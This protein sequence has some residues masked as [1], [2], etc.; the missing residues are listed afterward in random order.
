MHE[1]GAGDLVRAAAAGDGTAWEGLVRRYSG[2]VWSVA[3][4][5]GL[6]RADAAD[7]AQTTWLRLVEHLT[8][9]RDPEAV[10]AWLATTARYESLRVARKSGR[11]VPTE[12]DEA[13][14]ADEDDVA[15]LGERLHAAEYG[16]ALWQAFERLPPKCRALLRV[17]MAD[18]PPSYH[19]AAA[20]LGMPIG[21]LG[22][23]RARCL[24]RLRQDPGLAGY[25]AGR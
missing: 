23:I 15:A 17:L 14:P 24:A 7:V 11:M 6:G 25:Q 9:I 1:A 19:E 3:R 5:R 16:D 18:P 10:G 12:L 21:S 2:L 4:S 8:T 22:P 13:D 20:A